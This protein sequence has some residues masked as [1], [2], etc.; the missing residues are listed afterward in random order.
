MFWLFLEL[1]FV[2]E[3]NNLLSIAKG[4]SIRKNRSESKIFGI[5]WLKI[6]E[7]LNHIFSITRDSFAEKTP[8][9]DKTRDMIKI[10]VFSKKILINNNPKTI[11]S[12]VKDGLDFIFIQKE[13]K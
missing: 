10:F 4:D 11:V 2:W 1:K 3:L 9:P 8:N 6:K 5:I 7:N 13:Y 12:K